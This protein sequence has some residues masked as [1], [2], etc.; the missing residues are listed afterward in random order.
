[1]LAKLS[2]EVLYIVIAASLSDFP[3]GIFRIFQQILSAAKSSLNDIIHA[4]GTELLPVKCLDMAG[5][6]MKFFRHPV[7]IP[8]KL[9]IVVDFFM[10]GNQLVGVKAYR[11]IQGALP[12]LREQDTKQVRNICRALRG[13]EGGFPG[14]QLEQLMAVFGV[15]DRKRNIPERK[16]FHEGMV[17]AETNP[18]VS[19]FLSGGTVIDSASGRV[20]NGG[21]GRNTHDF[22]LCQQLCCRSD[23]QQKVARETIWH[24]IDKIVGVNSTVSDKINFIHCYFSPQ[25]LQIAPLSKLR[26]EGLCSAN[27]KV[28]VL[29]RRL[30]SCVIKESINYSIV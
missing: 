7:H 16:L 28:K 10:Q 6:Q 4:G 9:R 23:K 19:I 26:Q 14:Q 22:V 8:G 12:K 2:A 27:Y 15:G 30:I 1:M 29:C 21:I 5:T 18:V 20:Q 11:V 3:D 13:R 17:G 25:V 24:I